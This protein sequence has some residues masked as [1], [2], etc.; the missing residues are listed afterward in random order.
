MNYIYQFLNKNEEVIYV[1]ITQDIK[2]RIRSQHFTA[3]GHLPKDCYEEAEMVLYHECLSRDDAIIRE[4]YLINILGPK[5]NTL[6]NN[7]SRFPYEINDFKW[8]YIGVDKS[9]I[10]AEPKLRAPKV[11]KEV[12]EYLEFFYRKRRHPR[13]TSQD[14]E[15]KRLA[16][17]AIEVSIRFGSAKHPEAR[18]LEEIPNFFNILKSAEFSRLI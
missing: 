7:G 16:D 13:G 8:E 15:E 5:F 6:M 17:W 10:G 4:R 14:V 18:Y 11:P 3:G 9:G 2:T 12:S 1:G